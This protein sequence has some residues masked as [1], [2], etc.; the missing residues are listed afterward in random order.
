MKLAMMIL[1]T[2]LLVFGFAVIQAMKDTAETLRRDMQRYEYDRGN[3]SHN[4]SMLYIT[5]KLKRSA[6]Q[7]AA[8]MRAHPCP[9]NGKTKGK[10]PGYV[11]DHKVPLAC[12][13][14]DHPSNMQ[15]Q[16]AKEGKAKDKWERKGCR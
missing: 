6:S 8:F 7:R 3:L 12:G 9:A 2:T 11:V 16:T 10:C 15:W 14:R 13:G 5:V 1:L 4:S